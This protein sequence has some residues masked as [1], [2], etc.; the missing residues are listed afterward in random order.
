MPDESLMFRDDEEVSDVVRR[1]IQNRLP[2]M[3]GAKRSLTFRMDLYDHARLTWLAEQLGV[4]KSVLVRDL[5]AAAMAQAVNELVPEEED[6]E[7][8]REQFNSDT[9]QMLADQVRG[10]VG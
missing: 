2:D 1:H 5:L 9:Q 6:R 10:E 8:L 4:H 7:R 3:I